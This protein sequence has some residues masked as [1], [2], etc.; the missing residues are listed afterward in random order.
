MS[1]LQD[2]VIKKIAV[3]YKTGI[4][5]KKKKETSPILD[6]TFEDFFLYQVKL[7]PY[8][9]AVAQQS[10]VSMSPNIP[11]KPLVS[12]VIKSESCR[13]TRHTDCT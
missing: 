9:A 6:Q 4:K 10:R 5:K 3:V 2:K 13:T 11:V 8:I 7:S 1:E 12:L